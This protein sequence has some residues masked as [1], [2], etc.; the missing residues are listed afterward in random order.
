MQNLYRREGTHAY[1]DAGGD[2]M[3]TIETVM[4]DGHLVLRRTDGSTGSYAFKEVTF[5]IA[6]Q[7]DKPDS[8]GQKY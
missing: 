6:R 4:P 8:S 7:S 3:A 2:F 1:R 5:L